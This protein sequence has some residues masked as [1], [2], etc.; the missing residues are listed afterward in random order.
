MTWEERLLFLMFLDYKGALK[1]WEKNSNECKYG[2]RKIEDSYFN[3][4]DGFFWD[5]T[6]EGYDYWDELIADWGK[7]MERSLE[8][9][10]LD[11]KI[12]NIMLRDTI[13][14]GCQKITK[15]DALKIADFIYECFGDSE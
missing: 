11:F 9:R 10:S 4:I 8:V 14:V 2:Y 12:K 7:S 5:K 1:K 13:E 15:K 3:V 6:Q